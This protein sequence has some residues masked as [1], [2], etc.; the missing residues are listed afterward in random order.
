[1]FAETKH[2][3]ELFF[4]SGALPVLLSTAGISRNQEN[5]NRPNG[6]TTHHFLWVL[7]GEGVF[8]SGDLTFVL[9]EGTGVFFKAYTP[10]K[11]YRTTKD[12]RTA[13]FTFYGLDGLI[14]YYEITKPIKFDVPDFLNLPYFN[15]EELSGALTTVVSRSA[16]TYSLITD[17]FNSH[18]KTK[19]TLSKLVEQY[20]ENHFY[21]AITLDFLAEHFNMTR[22]SLCHKYN[23]ES[24]TTIFDTLTKI[25][26]A[27]AKRYLASTALPINEIGRMCGF[28]SPSYFCKIFKE[29]THATPAGYRKAHNKRT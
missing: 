24:G 7:E 22:F 16:K 6:I 29:L 14:E 4:E 15:L 5:I 18:F 21:E 3:C 27:K 28:Y 25:R 9:K 1:M 8:E 23:K 12:F 20:L 13:W 19:A 26:I 17:I 2:N 11:Y 10:H